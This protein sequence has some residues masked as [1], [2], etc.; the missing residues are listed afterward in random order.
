[1]KKINLF[2]AIVCFV[3]FQ[4]V[5]HAQLGIGVFYNRI[6]PNTPSYPSLSYNMDDMIGVEVD[7][8]FRLKKYRLEF[9]PTIY[10][11]SDI[12]TKGTK[13]NHVNNYSTGIIWKNVLYPFDF[14]D[15]CDCPNFSKGQF[16]IKKSFFVLFNIGAGYDDMPL[17]QI[18]DFKLEKSQGWHWIAGMGLGFDIGIS[19][20]YTISPY[21]AY[22]FTQSKNWHFTKDSRKLHIKSPLSGLVVG[23]RQS[24][25]FDY[26]DRGKMR[27]N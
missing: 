10:F 22:Q 19:D 17:F 26:R 20:F 8:W 3:F 4:H 23:V 21:I 7:W 27:F 13:Q 15:D 12:I 18:E 2:V 9:L 11:Q 16:D 24:F 1:M 6:T 25:R 14:L 5:V